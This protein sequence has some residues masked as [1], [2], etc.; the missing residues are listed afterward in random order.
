MAAPKRKV[1]AKG[2]KPKSWYSI[3]SPEFLGAKE[4]GETPTNDG[5]SL[6]NRV[7]QVPMSTLTGNFRQFKT[8]VK[9]RVKR[10]DGKKAVTEYD[11]QALTDDEISRKVHRW[12]SRVDSVE[13]VTTQDGKKMRVK[14]IAVTT[15]RVNTSV[16]DDIRHEMAK[17]VKAFAKDRKVD[18]F[19]NDVAANV[20]QKKARDPLAK[21]HPVRSVDVRK[22]EMLG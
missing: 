21:I 19:V 1:Q 10:L 22:V 2:K 6:L 20:L 12:S 5:K 11:G 8:N 13:D 17:Q 15:R 9:L 4:L 14:M 3:V 18:K 16:K 7:I